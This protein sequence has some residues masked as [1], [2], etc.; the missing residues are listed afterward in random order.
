[1]AICCPIKKAFHSLC[2]KSSS[3]FTTLNDTIFTF[4]VSG[5]DKIEELQQHENEQV[6]QTAQNLID[7]FFQTEVIGLL[8]S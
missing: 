6:F 8:N 2:F 5:L 7:K 4:N 1:M 3:S